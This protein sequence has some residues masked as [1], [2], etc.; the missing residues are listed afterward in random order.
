MKNLKGKK[1]VDTVLLFTKPPVAGRV[2]TRLVG[3]L[4]ARQA[5]DLHAA[6]LA[7]LVA[8]ISGQNFAL[9]PVW[10]LQSGEAPPQ[11]PH[12]GKRQVEG[13]LGERL[14]H[15]FAELFL[16]AAGE[17]DAGLAVA[18]GSDLPQ[19][20]PQRLEEAFHA[21]A[22]GAD[23]VLGPARDGGYYLIG[24]RAEALRVPLFE[25]IAW[26]T[27]A[28]LAQTLARCR[29]AG[30]T[31]ALLPEEEDIDTADALDR[32]AKRLA[33]GELAACPR[34]SALLAFWGRLGGAEQRDA[35]QENACGS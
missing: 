17:E 16:A 27:A 29:A 35:R 19:L 9:V 32:F 23:V 34:T 8:R 2:K 24:L 12:G 33:A 21:L 10:A 20:E 1:A 13:D 18:I 28:V 15:S 3:A 11:E 22:S 7:D 14:R 4:T 26:S 6:F 5:A 31:A 25:E 30:L